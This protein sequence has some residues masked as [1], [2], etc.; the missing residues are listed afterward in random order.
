MCDACARLLEEYALHYTSESERVEAVKMEEEE[1]EMRKKVKEAEGVVA[2]VSTCVHTLF[3]VLQRSDSE[4]VSEAL[5]VL[6]QHARLHPQHLRPVELS[7][8]LLGIDSNTLLRILTLLTRWP[9]LSTVAL[10]AQLLYR[11]LL[12]VMSSHSDMFRAL[13][14]QHLPTLVHNGMCTP[15]SP[16]LSLHWCSGDER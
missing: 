7:R 9:L 11:T 6:L 16:L 12:T 2:V 15:L 13:T 3:E 10:W 8:L 14:T 1:E 4:Y 5:V